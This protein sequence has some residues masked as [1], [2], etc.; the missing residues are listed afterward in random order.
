MK[1]NREREQKQRQGSKTT[2]SAP[3]L[4]LRQLLAGIA[5]VIILIAWPM[6]M[7]WKQ[8]YIRNISMRESSL[9]DSLSGLSKEAATLRLYNEKLS[10]IQRI[11]AIA[12]GSLSLEY[13]TSAQ[14]VVIRENRKDLRRDS[15]GGG[16]LLAILRKTFSR[17]RG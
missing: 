17:E 6:F 1:K 9:A 14:I 8:I 11:E 3:V 2:G 7:V 12:R 4:K 15:P 10:G 13:P 5:C 16:G